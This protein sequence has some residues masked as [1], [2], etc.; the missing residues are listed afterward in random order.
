MDLATALHWKPFGTLQFWEEIC[1]GQE[2]E[3]FPL[4]KLCWLKFREGR[5]VGAVLDLLFAYILCPF[6]I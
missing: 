2:A 3:H 4:S 6:L 1:N 5:G